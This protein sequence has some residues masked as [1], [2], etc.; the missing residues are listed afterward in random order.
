M[1]SKPTK[2]KI[3]QHALT[4]ADVEGGAPMSPTPPT[5]PVSETHPHH[6][7]EEEVVA[8]FV[9]IMFMLMAAIA[10]IFTVITLAMSWTVFPFWSRDITIVT[11]GLR[12][13]HEVFAFSYFVNNEPG[14]RREPSPFLVG[15]VIIVGSETNDFTRIAALSIISLY[16]TAAPTLVLDVFVGP[17]AQVVTPDFHLM[18]QNLFAASFNFISDANLKQNIINIEQWTSIDAIRQLTPVSFQFRGTTQTH[19]GFTAQ[20]VASVIPEAVSVAGGSGA[21]IDNGGADLM[22]VDMMALLAHTVNALKNVNARL[23]ALE[24][25]VVTLTK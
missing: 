12:T 19:L 22:G 23:E 25:P 10:L 16:F 11:D 17:I 6:H 1:S 24:H 9:V 14:L 13:D 21:L 4:T 5:A 7:H 18:E 8:N 20:S 15:D 2:R 3:A